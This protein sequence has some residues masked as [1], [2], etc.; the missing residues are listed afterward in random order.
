VISIII[1]VISKICVI[2]GLVV[3]FIGGFAVENS[4]EIAIRC[5][6]IACIMLLP[7]III[8]WLECRYLDKK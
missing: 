6:G 5:M 1:K 7:E 2:V 8:D 3:A 4:F